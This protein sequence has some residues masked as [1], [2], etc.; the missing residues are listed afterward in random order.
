MV[1]LLG[2]VVL[3]HGLPY[4]KT[5]GSGFQR[6]SDGLF[7]SFAVRANGFGIVSLSSLAPALKYVRNT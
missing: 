1:G 4:Y 3:D 7:Q 5:L 2:F 6:F